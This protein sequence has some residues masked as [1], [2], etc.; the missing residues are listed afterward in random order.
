MKD[1]DTFVRGCAD[2]S[3]CFLRKR[4]S[5]VWCCD[6]QLCNAATRSA[7]RGRSTTLQ[8]LILLFLFLLFLI[9][10]RTDDLSTCKII[11]VCILLLCNDMT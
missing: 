8:A 9:S 5:Y 1:S 3:E 4:G 6:G 2:E 10:G 11:A 7:G